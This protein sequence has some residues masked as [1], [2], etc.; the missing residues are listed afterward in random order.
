MIH[1]YVERLKNNL[2]YTGSDSLLMLSFSLS[3]ILGELGKTSSLQKQVK[4]IW[5][6]YTVM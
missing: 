3:S 5:M 1:E 2:R 4:P 6:K